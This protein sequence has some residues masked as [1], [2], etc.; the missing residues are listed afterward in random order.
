MSICEPDRLQ[1]P[2]FGDDTRWDLHLYFSFD[3]RSPCG[4]SNVHSERLLGRQHEND[5]EEHRPL[6]FEN[7]PASAKY[8]PVLRE[9][10]MLLV[11]TAGATRSKLSRSLS[12]SRRFGLKATHSRCPAGRDRNY[13]QP[14]SV[15]PAL[16]EICPR[17]RGHP[18]IASVQAREPRSQ[19]GKQRRD[20]TWCSGRRRQLRPVFAGPC[21]VE[22]P[23][24]TLTIRRA[25]RSA[26]AQSA[27]RRLQAR[28][29][30]YAF[31]GLGE[32][33]LVILRDVG[34]RIG[35]R[36]VSEALDRASSTRDGHWT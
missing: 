27:R 5:T 14:G 10:L 22:T 11:M 35:M 21:S 1:V 16:F 12:G 18:G 31:Q 20:G 17:T 24:Q 36:S 29:S 9:R 30:P 25:V 34:P 2:V 8:S 13:G 26:G 4:V 3:Q 23:E 33:G 7:L 32:P 6:H 19:V 15:E 28:T